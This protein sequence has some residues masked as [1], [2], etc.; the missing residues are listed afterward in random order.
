M[1]TH[2]GHD[3]EGIVPN[4]GLKQEIFLIALDEFYRRSDLQRTA[5]PLSAAEYGWNIKQSRR[6]YGSG[7]KRGWRTRWRGT[8]WAWFIY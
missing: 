3:I 4:I 5:T 6:W 2:G 8:A 7:K 1:S